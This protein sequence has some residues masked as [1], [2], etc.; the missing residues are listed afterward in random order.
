MKYNSKGF[1]LIEIMVVMILIAI[2]TSLVVTKVGKSGRMRQSR[3]F[4]SDLISLCK[5]ARLQAV[6]KGLPACISISSETRKCW[7]SLNENFEYDE[8]ATK[9]KR[10]ITIPENMLIEGEQ[11]KSNEDG[12][13]FICFYPDSSSGGGILTLSVEDDFVFTFRVDMLTGIIE[14]VVL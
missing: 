10:K 12:I 3:M 9:G 4:A 8:K 11:V 5:Q 14:V 2:S 13:Y 6:S 7:I 1:T